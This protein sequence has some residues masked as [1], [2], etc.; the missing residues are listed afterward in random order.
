VG[1]PDYLAPEQARDPET[2]DV[3]ADVYSLG[4]T[5]YELLTGRPPFPDGTLVQ[6][7]LAHQERLPRPVRTVRPEVPVA[8]DTLLARM[9]AKNPAQRP[10]PGEAARL[11]GELPQPT[12]ARPARRSIVAM[13]LVLLTTAVVAASAVAAAVHFWPKS[14]SPAA[15]TIATPTQPQT[16]VGGA[17]LRPEQL[18]QRR[19]EMR[20]QTLEWVR[21]NNRWKPDA[22]IVQNIAKTANRSLAES[23]GFQVL[24]G[25]K[26]V[27]SGRPTLLTAHTGGWSVFELPAEPGMFPRLRDSGSLIVPFRN[28]DDERLLTPMATL[29]NLQLD[30]R[31]SMPRGELMT[32]TVMYQ[33][34]A[35][36]PAPLFLRLM[37]Y[38]NSGKVRCLG[39]F[40]PRPPLHEGTGTLPF[41][42]PGLNAD[43][44]RYDEVI[45]V[46]V[47]L[48]RREEDGTTVVVSNTLA[49]RI[50]PA[51]S[52]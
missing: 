24:L 36:S 52:R 29:S 44:T 28:S 39:M 4:C 13:G 8:V 47:D 1:T 30:K 2:A 31:E 40:H 22:E 12:S 15:Q 17:L 34:P 33:I 46:F 18:R 48:A 9:L 51:R 50:L 6:K 10:A 37:Y 49:D 7:L 3:R 23:D 5:L 25:P 35:R 11:L 14:P 27:R 45:A 19:E 43:L 20:D 41:R 26:L 42:F 16:P 32:G 38:P 21:Q